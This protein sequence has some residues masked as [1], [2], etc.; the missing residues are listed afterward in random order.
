MRPNPLR[1]LA[2]C[3]ALAAPALASVP[4]NAQPAAPADPAALLSQ[5]RQWFDQGNKLYDA[6]K[7]PE[8]EAAYLKAWTL[9]KSYDV[10]G[11]LGNVDADMK[12]WRAAAEYLAFAIREFPAGGKPA[13]RDGLIQRLAEAQKQVGRLRLRV[14]KPGAEVFVDGASAGLAPL[15]DDVYVDPGSHLVEIRLDGY[16]P[17]Q[18]TLAATRAQVTEAEIALKSGGANKTVIIAG[19]AVAGVAAITGAVL[20]GVSASKGSSASS[21]YTTLKASGGCPPASS[22][23]TGQC[24]QL[25]S[26]LDAKSTLGS[27]GVWM[28]VGAGVVGLGT[29]VYGL[30]GGPR[31]ARTGL[32]TGPRGIALAP[33]VTADG[34]GVFA[35]GSF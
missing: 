12:K 11:N 3:A 17:T 32:V 18:V 8:A 26:D 29:L 5:Q 34:G 13:Q 7:L 22:S 14:S 20:L 6:N 9:K 35:Q 27:A 4:A 21:L 23:P 10:A 16:P 15:P 25:K 24:G 33:V 30:A 19:A 31:A 2:V 1:I 28:L